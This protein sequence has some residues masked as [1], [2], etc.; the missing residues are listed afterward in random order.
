MP[1]I[2]FANVLRETVRRIK[3]GADYNWCHMGRCNCGHIAQTITKKSPQEIHELALLKSG[4]W[5]DQSIEHCNSTGYTIDHIIESILAFGL[6]RQEL[7]YIERLSNP[8]VLRHI[9][10]ARRKV[11]N[12][13]KKEDVILYFNTWAKVIEDEYFTNTDV[14]EISFFTEDLQKYDKLKKPALV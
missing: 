10:P 7:A 5:K 6:S 2:K 12:F 4:D 11:L 1:D 9:E 3:A 14:P 13:K 8:Q